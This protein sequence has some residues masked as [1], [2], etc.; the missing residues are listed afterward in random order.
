MNSGQKICRNV[1]FTRCLL[2]CVIEH[3]A[4][5]RFRLC[6]RLRNRFLKLCCGWV[7]PVLCEPFTKFSVFVEQHPE[8]LRDDKSGSTVDEFGVLPEFEV[9]VFLDADLNR[10]IVNQ[11]WWGFQDGVLDLRIRSPC[12]H[13]GFAYAVFFGD[14]GDN[15]CQ[16]PEY[17]FFP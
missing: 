4:H 3:G 5:A 15:K 7:A 8:R 2:R 1:L 13:S 12:E 6:R 14:K 16:T 9:D 10:R 11:F 17:G